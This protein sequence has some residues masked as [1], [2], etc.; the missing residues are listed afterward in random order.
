MLEGDAE[1]ADPRRSDGVAGKDREIEGVRRGA[2]H[3]RGGVRPGEGKR[4]RFADPTGRL[5]RDREIADRHGERELPEPVMG[6]GPGVLVALGLG[7]LRRVDGM[8]DPLLVIGIGRH[9]LF[10][11]A[12]LGDRLPPGGFLPLVHLDGTD[13]LELVG[14]RH[15]ENGIGE[16]AGGNGPAGEVDELPL[17]RGIDRGRGDRE[18]AF[19][20]LDEGP[21]PLDGAPFV[22]EKE[23]EG[24]D[25]KHEADEDA[26]D[27]AAQFLPVGTPCRGC[28][29][30][31]HL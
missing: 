2:E 3:P 10:A 7:E 31:S 28:V 1:I 17:V 12:D 21:R 5:L 15:R 19:R 6:E 22:P 26:H 23:G 27:R 24:S 16:D 18:D 30:V 9:R 4:S 20:P 13:Q 8:G 11:A 29:C 25:E 14:D